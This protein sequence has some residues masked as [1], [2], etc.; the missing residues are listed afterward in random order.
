MSEQRFLTKFRALGLIA[1][2]LLLAAAVFGATQVL[3]KS[4]LPP[5]KVHQIHLS[6]KVGLDCTQ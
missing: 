2:T 4:K 6:P 5:E 3:A 1:A